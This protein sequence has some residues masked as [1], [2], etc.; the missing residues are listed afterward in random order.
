MSTVTGPHLHDTTASPR[1]RAATG[2]GAP[3]ASEISRLL[4]RRL[5][6]ALLAVG[7]VALVVAGVAL[8]AT[9]GTDVTGARVTAEADYQRSLADQRSYRAQCLADPGI[10]EGEKQVQCGTGEADSQLS[11]DSFFVDPRL[12]ADQGLPELA[13]GTTVV[14][15]V[16]LALVGAT[17]VGAD[18]SSRTMLSLLTWQPRR[19]RFLATRLGAI[20]VLS[21]AASVLAQALALGMGALVV[22]TRG[23]FDATPE[24]P[25]GTYVGSAGQAMLA[26]AHFWR[27][28]LSLQ[29]RGI[30]V[31][32]LA[33]LVA[34]GLATLTRGTGGFL[35]VT[36][37]WL[38]L[39][40]VAGQAL[41]LGRAPSLVPWTL[42]QSAAAALQPG[43]LRLYLDQV[44]TPRGFEQ[45]T[46]LVSNLDGLSHLGLLA[47]V[48][49]VAAG[50]LLRR[51]DL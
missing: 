37:A 26:Q 42:T 11:A 40:E 39:V 6:L 19:L 50:V 45:R 46:Q 29:A 24:L 30:A 27:D 5:V 49:L 22:A 13:I 21:L 16:L 43:G 25:S 32:V 48:V 12:R 3:L 10:P 2:L 14:G 35:G 9:H 38:V 18:W 1:P 51:R 4:H 36:L 28:L 8:F 41:L 47:V 23:T 33:A 17:A 7:A 34:A 15:A 31:M 20:T 44:Q